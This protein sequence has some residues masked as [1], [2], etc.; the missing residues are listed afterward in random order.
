MEGAP[1]PAHYVRPCIVPR[2]P[3]ATLRGLPVP[4]HCSTLFS[5]VNAQKR[6][7]VLGHDVP[8]LINVHGT[9]AGGAILRGQVFWLLVVVRNIW[10]AVVDMVL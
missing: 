9:Q 1:S 3:H 6:I 2:R 7:C 8:Q 10:A 5:L 4:H